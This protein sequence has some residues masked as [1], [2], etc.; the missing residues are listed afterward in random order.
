MKFLY[1]IACCMILFSP[2]LCHTSEIERSNSVSDL[3]WLIAE[4]DGSSQE[5][6]KPVITTNENEEFNPDE[7][8]IEDVDAIAKSMYDDAVAILSSISNGLLSFSRFLT[9]DDSL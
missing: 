4:K 3:D 7:H 8:I 6:E 5:V 9:D 2:N 1:V